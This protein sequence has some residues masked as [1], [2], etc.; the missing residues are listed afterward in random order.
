[1]KQITNRL[2][3]WMGL[4]LLL[5]VIGYGEARAYVWTQEPSG[6]QILLDHAFDTI[7][8]PGM[9]NPY[10]AGSI[11]QLS[12][13]G[14]I[15]PTNVYKSAILPGF[16]FGGSE[17]HYVSPTVQR[18]I[19]VGFMWRM[20]PEFYGRQ[21]ANK[22]FFL[23]G[24]VS[25]GFFGLNGGPGG[26]SDVGKP[27][28]LMFGPNVSNVDNSHACAGGGLT[29][30]PI[31]I[32]ASTVTPGEWTEIQVYMKSSTSNTSRDGIVRWWVKG[33]LAGNYTNL[34]ISSAGLNEWVW[35]ETWDGTVNPVPT[36]EWDHFIDHLHISSPAC[37]SG[38]C[39]PVTP[40]ATPPPPP[41]QS[42]DY[43]YSQ[44]F[45]N[46]QG[47]GQWS[48]RDTAGN[49]MTYDA[50]GSIWRGDE[51]YLAIW[52]GGF[53]NGF[54][55]AHKGAVLRWTAPAAGTTSITGTA[56][57]YDSPGAGLFSIKY[58]N[59][60]VL[61]SQ[62]MSAGASYPYNLTQAVSAGD[63]IDFVMSEVSPGTSRN[64]QLDPVINFTPSGPLGAPTVS[65][66]TPT[67]GDVGAAVTITGTNFGTTVGENTV[68]FNGVVAIC[69][70]ASATS[71]ICP[72]PQGATTGAITVTTTAGTGTSA[73]NFTVTTAT[74]TKTVSVFWSYSGLDVNGNREAVDHFEILRSDTA[75]GTYTQIGTAPASS[76]V[77]IDTNA[78]LQKAYY[79]VRVVDKSSNVSALSGKVGIYDAGVTADADT[80]AP[81]APFSVGGSY[82]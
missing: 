36:V 45:S 20:N 1:M 43:V 75:G 59:S 53:V 67:S 46:V 60:T 19:F 13:A 9:T 66:F 51:L 30:M 5:V 28:Y 7:L 15:S 71:L 72:L 79:K 50:S 70:G 78:P 55:G 27:F 57:L 3:R 4:A 80:D 81:A 38:G 6:S 64:T 26:G 32:A 21:V 12:E 69:S 37:P 41:P 62:S 77:F 61:F 33:V 48:Y 74:P 49:L 39:T 76:R 18:E 31:S 56:K 73:S 11:T 8:G 17:L 35:S 82:H 42:G 29:C 34:N 58:N 47:Q 16:N 44:Q 25:N 54:S 22:L 65:S 68:K 10:N 2:M 14:M 23:R 63:T 40:P 24:P 52:N